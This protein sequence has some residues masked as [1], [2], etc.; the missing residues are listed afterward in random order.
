[1]LSCME[2]ALGL[3]VIGPSG[4]PLRIQRSSPAFMA[5]RDLLKRPLPAEQAWVQLQELVADPRKAVISWCE[6]FG[7]M[8]RFKDD[9]L[10]LNDKPLNPVAWLPL[11]SRTMSAGGAPTHLLNFA[12]RLGDLASTARVAQV[13]LHV[14]D[15]GQLRPPSVLRQAYLPEK[16]L[17]GD[18][19]MDKT[20]GTIPFLVSY[21]DY[22][23]TETGELKVKEGLVLCPLKDVIELEDTLS[24]PQILG[25]NRTYR[26]EEGSADG[27][28]EDLSF[29][30]LLA[31]RRNA[32]EIQASGSEARII[33]RITGDVVSLL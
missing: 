30:S 33:N 3:M 8:L 32:K 21:H 29:D 23:L 5:S 17:R 15:R 22:L 26:C 11:L 12:D 20:T 6:R 7:L 9:V 16:A 24:Q 18:I 25:F 4:Q 31:A 19:V 2:T 14:P 13:G 27:W 1:M 28:L 10:L